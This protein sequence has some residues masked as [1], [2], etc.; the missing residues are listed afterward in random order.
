MNVILDHPN[1]LT[2]PCFLQIARTSPCWSRECL[3][4]YEC[5]VSVTLWRI[6]FRRPA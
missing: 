1:S 3:S 2:N 4:S 6:Q 5:K